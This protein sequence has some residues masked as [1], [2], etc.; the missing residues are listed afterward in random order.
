MPTRVDI[1]S[2]TARALRAADLARFR[3]VLGFDGF[4]DDIIH[5]VDKR[6]SADQWDRLA[7]LAEFGT[8]VSAAAES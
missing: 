2:E 8:R 4:V 3:G 1:A 6:Q 5:V 7:T